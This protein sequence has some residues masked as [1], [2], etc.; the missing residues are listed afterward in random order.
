MARLPRRLRWHAHTSRA[1]SVRC[2]IFRGL[3]AG[4]YGFAIDCPQTLSGF[5]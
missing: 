5:A 1:D 3:N 2:W 4:H